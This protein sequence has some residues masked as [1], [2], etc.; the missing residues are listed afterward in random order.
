MSNATE[1][2]RQALRHLEWCD[3]GCCDEPLEEAI[4]AYL[5]AEPAIRKPMTEEEIQKHSIFWLLYDQKSF[6]AGIRFAEKH[7]GIGVDDNG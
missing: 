2:L 5:A 1:L 6:V 3:E 7:H 4:R